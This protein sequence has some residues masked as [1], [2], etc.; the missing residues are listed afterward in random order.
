MLATVATSSQMAAGG[1]SAAASGGLGAAVG[2][3]LR[4]LTEEERQIIESVMAR[5]REEEA[6]EH[7]LIR[8]VFN[9]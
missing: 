7:Q 2:P 6:R 5:Q 4:H 1:S 3:D 8:Y 9:Y